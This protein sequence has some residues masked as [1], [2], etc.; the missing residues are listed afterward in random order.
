MERAKISVERAIEILDPTHREHYNELPDGMAQVIEACLMG[1][2][3]LQDKLTVE[4]NAPLTTDELNGM[5]GLP[6]WVEFEPSPD[7]ETLTMWALLEVSD[8]I[9]LT[10]NLRGQSELLDDMTIEGWRVK[11]YRREPVRRGR[12]ETWIGSLLKCSVCG[13]EYCDKVEANRF[14]GN[15][16]ARMEEV[17]K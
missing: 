2:G 10:N 9:M 17:E 1:M 15:C 13:Y 3:A 7:G 6:V 5:D 12:W 11:V 14:C 4:R 8:T 16:G